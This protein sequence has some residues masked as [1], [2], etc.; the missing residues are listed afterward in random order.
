MIKHVSIWGGSAAAHI[1]TGD[2]LDGLRDLN[3]RCVHC[4]VTSPPYWA[5]RNYGSTGQLGCEQTPEEYTAR[6]VDVFKEVRRVLRDDGVLFLNIGDTYRNGQ[7]LGIP[8]RVA[9]ALADDGWL[10]RQ[11]LIWHKPNPMPESVRDRCTKAHE[12]V[13]LFAKRA[14]YFWDGQAICEPSKTAGMK[15]MGVYPSRAEAMGRKPS[16]NESKGPSHGVRPD[17]RNRRSVWT[18]PVGSFRGAH[19]ATMPWMLARLCIEAGTSAAGCC[20]VC[21]TPL[22]RAVKRVRTATRPGKDTKATGDSLREGNRDPQRHVT[23]VRTIGWAPACLCDG[24]DAV[25]CTVLDPFAG[26]GTTLAESLQL[27]RD[28]IGIELNPEYVELIRQRINR[29]QA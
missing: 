23:T 18:I 28:C 16:G 29:V 10:L 12:Y 2:A 4:C 3:D 27:G 25:P 21:H 11:D 24:G 15:G 13:F 19:F 6:L 22:A 26:S 8:W 1:I 20:P 14:G 9:F 5:L 7:A 17:T